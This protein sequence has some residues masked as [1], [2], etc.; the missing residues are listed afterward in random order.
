MGE[1]VNGVEEY[2][3]FHYF[4]ACGEKQM[5][6]DQGKAGSHGE[7]DKGS[8]QKRGEPSGG[9]GADG[10]PDLPSGNQA[11]FSKALLALMKAEM[12]D[13]QALRSIVEGET[14]TASGRTI[15]NV[16][17]EGGHTALHCAVLHGKTQIV[18]YLLE[19]GCQP[20]TIASNWQTALHDAIL[21]GNH[22]I[23]SL[24][25]EFGAPNVC[26]STN[27]IGELPLHTVRFSFYNPMEN[28]SMHLF[29]HISLRQRFM[30]GY[31]SQFTDIFDFRLLN[32]SPSPMAK[33]SFGIF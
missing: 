7:K 19:H 22:D 12:S 24:L 28:T 29:H 23:V 33:R 9:V 25:L 1:G 16:K 18:K 21:L 15:D 11:K 4:L 5:G 14:Y 3:K 2:K 20:R 32:C 6:N 26:L 31:K 27:A 10:R 8:K 17:S 13:M 30:T